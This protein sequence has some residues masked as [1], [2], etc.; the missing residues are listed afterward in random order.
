MGLI[1]RFYFSILFV[2]LTKGHT[3]S[4]LEQR[5]FMLIQ[6]LCMLVALVS[7]YVSSFYLTSHYT[8]RRVGRRQSL[9]FERLYLDLLHLPL[10]RELSRS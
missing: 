6:P 1:F 3:E 8:R 2:W 10:L 9:H 7:S 4:A 5:T